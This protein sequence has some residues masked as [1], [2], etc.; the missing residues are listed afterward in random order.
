[1]NQLIDKSMQK[2]VEDL[3]ATCKLHLIEYYENHKND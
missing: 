2:Q 3:S 1:M